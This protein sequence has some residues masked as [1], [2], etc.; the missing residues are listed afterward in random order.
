MISSG[1]DAL[2]QNAQTALDDTLTA[3]ETNSTFQQQIVSQMLDGIVN[4]YSVAYSTIT[5]IIAGSGDV[6]SSTLNNVLSDTASSVQKV[7]DLV[8]DAKKSID[9]GDN[10]GTGGDVTS[11]L[12]DSEGGSTTSTKLADDLKSASLSGTAKTMV[13]NVAGQ[14]V[15]KNT[16]NN[17]GTGG[18][19]ISQT[20]TVAKST[21]TATTPKASV[22]PTSISLY[23][24]ETKVVKISNGTAKSAS[25]KTCKVT[26][27][28]NQVVFYGTKAGSET[29]TIVTNNGNVSVKVKVSERKTSS[30]VNYF[31]KY[32]GKS[33]SI[34][35][36]LS[37][38]GAKSSYDYRKKIAAANN[39]KN[40]K[41]TAAQ[42]TQMLQLLKL[43]KLIKPK[44][45]GGMI[46]QIIPIKGM[47]GGD[48][49]LA[50]VQ[51]GEAVL[52][53]PFMQDVVPEFMKTVKQ[54]TALLQPIGNGGEVNVHYDS[55]LTVNGNV[56][57]D[58]LPGLRDLLQQ[59]YE[60]TSQ[61][62]YKDLSKLGFK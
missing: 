4:N 1:Y 31:K 7:I 22:S 36:A 50:S 60:Y 9:N 3:L 12:S 25:S 33:V 59:S 18:N 51:I 16:S 6:I 15:D 21:T 61:K 29:V 62:M 44:A 57:K 32:T 28:S 41:G 38:V 37:T 54:T 40:Y 17:Q 20:Q 48:D 55:L 10:A 45:K 49:G 24:H 53:R 47:L 30:K 56:D 11:T 14:T 27:K 2:S 35:D 52:S 58:A 42:N 23:V 46:D 34:V 8:N 26:V 13:D 5:D 43:G 39:I 19:T